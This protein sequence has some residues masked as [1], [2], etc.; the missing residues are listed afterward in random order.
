MIDRLLQI[1]LEPVARDRSA[2]AAV[3]HLDAAAGWRR[4][5]RGCSSFSSTARPAGFRRGCSCCCSLPRWS[6]RSSSGGR[7]KRTPLDFQTIARNIEAE[8]PKLHALLLTAVEQKPDAATQELN[9]LQDRVIREA[10][11]EDRRSVWRKRAAKQL[12]LTQLGN[13]AAL[14]LL[15]GRVAHAVSGRA[16]ARGNPQA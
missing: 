2:V 5:A 13:V 15:A 7:S 10:L 12:R 6:G 16:A 1:H 14:A 4:R 3:A 9:Y 11:A 8:N